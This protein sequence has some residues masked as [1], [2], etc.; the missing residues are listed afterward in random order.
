MWYVIVIRDHRPVA[1]L[2]D[3]TSAA[4]G[5]NVRAPAPTSRTGT[6]SGSFLAWRGLLAVFEGHA[7]GGRGEGGGGQRAGGATLT[8]THHPPQKQHNAPPLRGREDRGNT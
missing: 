8:T 7:R 4:R 5:R 2:R 3:H 1:S 6:G